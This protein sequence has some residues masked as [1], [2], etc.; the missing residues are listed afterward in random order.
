MFLRPCQVLGRSE[1]RDRPVQTFLKPTNFG[2]YYK[3]MDYRFLSPWKKFS[4]K[5]IFLKIYPNEEAKRKTC[6]KLSG[7]IWK[8]FPASFSA[9]KY[10][11]VHLNAFAPL[12]GLKKA[13]IKRLIDYVFG[14]STSL[15]FF[16]F[17]NTS[18][19]CLFRAF[20]FLGFFHFF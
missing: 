9:E 19:E 1:P 2:T 8:H 17:R 3:I 6:W 4:G 18:E 16:W 11:G 10:F 7:A 20:L 12:K 15:W 5:N 14:F 13:K